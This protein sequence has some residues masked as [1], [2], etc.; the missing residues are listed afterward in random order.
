MSYARRASRLENEQHVQAMAVV[1]RVRIASP[2]LR[3]EHLL[4]LI[5]ERLTPLVRP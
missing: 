4:A 2:P 3:A 1:E 5:E